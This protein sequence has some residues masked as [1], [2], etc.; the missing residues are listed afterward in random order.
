[1]NEDGNDTP[2]PLGEVPEFRRIRSGPLPPHQNI[3]PRRRAPADQLPWLPSAAARRRR[4]AL[5]LCGF[6][7]AVVL[8]VSGSSWAVTGWL[9]DQLHRYDVFTGLLDENRP[10][11]SQGALNFLVIGSDDRSGLDSRQRSELGVG[12]V[13]GRRSDT[14]MLV[15]LNHQREHITVVGIPRDSWVRIP[16]H[17]PDKI[18][19]AYSLGGPQL[20]VQTV[21][22]ATG[23]RIDHYV[24]IDFTGFVEVVDTLGGITVCLPEAIHDEKA[25]LSL[26]AGTHRLQ[27]TQALAFARTRKS[28][29]G[30]LDRIDRQQ[31][32]LA[33]LLDEALN[34][35]ILSDPARLAQFV[36]TALGSI[37]VDDTLDTAA[38][39]Q[40]GTQLRSLGLDDVTFTQV[41]VDR[42]DFW[43]PSGEVAVTWHE[44]HATELFTAIAA[45]RPIPQPQSAEDSALPSPD[46][47]T[48]EVYNGTTIPGL[49]AQVRV[50]LL[51]SGFQVPESA[52]NWP[53]QDLAETLV[54]YSPEREDA[55][56]LLVES[57]PGARAEVDPGL[58]GLLQ[59]IAGVNHT[60]VAVPA[61]AA[62]PIA[63][64]PVDVGGRETVHT[65]TAAENVCR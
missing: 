24:E 26:E 50:E 33:A 46:E 47:V 10:P 14:M 53:Q 18:N 51:E 25:H 52:G 37:T 15:H 31:Q 43:T 27:G 35:Q 2:R 29:H 60:G 5:L 12:N 59:V 9:S 63:E 44:Q 39:I 62:S 11:A 55:A 38:L 36:E 34:A 20:A 61:H 19:A 28:P 56:T 32:V 40:L 3:P 57:I 58:G 13:E 21:E 54:R 1:M 8:L 17:G 48:V 64:Q 7:S 22:A 30:D 41:P 45:D 65:R 49:G 4:A 23:V 42:I 6:L 16:G